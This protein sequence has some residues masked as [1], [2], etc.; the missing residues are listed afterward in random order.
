MEIDYG[1][2]Q[3]YTSFH[4]QV[5][6]NITGIKWSEK[7]SNK[8]LWKMTKQ[9]PVMQLQQENGVGSAIHWIEEH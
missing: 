8:N 9:E 2:H 7:I 4:Q 6:K 5:P 3:N 1:F